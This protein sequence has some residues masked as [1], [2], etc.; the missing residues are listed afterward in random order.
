[1][2][3]KVT[4]IETPH[5]ILNNLDHSLVLGAIAHTVPANFVDP[6]SLYL[7]HVLLR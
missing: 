5:S 4:Y 3:R 1:M 6:R 7:T 2:P